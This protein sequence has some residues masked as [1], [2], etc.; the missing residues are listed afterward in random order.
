[1]PAYILSPFKPSPVALYAGTPVYLWGSYNDKTGPTLGTVLSDSG[2]GTTSTVTFQITSGNIPLVGALITII[3]TGN[4]GGAYNVTNATILSVSTT[5]S[6]ACTVTFANTATS[7]SAPDSGFVQIPQPEVAEVV[8]VP[9]SAVTESSAPC[10]IA[11]QNAQSNQGRGLTAVVSNP[12]PMASGTITLQQAVQDID[13]E[14]A[15]VAT[16]ATVSAGVLIGGQITIQE[17][18]GRFY[19]FHLSGYAQSG[20]TTATLVGKILA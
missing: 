1:M 8:P 20:T 6:G 13:S 3:G 18:L 14:Y 2:N 16:V 7:T 19:R 12:T 11:F 15:D 9:L 5:T 17:V 10:A 4:D